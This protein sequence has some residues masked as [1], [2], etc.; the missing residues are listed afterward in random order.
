[1]KQGK[2]KSKAKNKQQT[3]KLEVRGLSKRP[4]LRI[5]RGDLIF[6]AYYQRPLPMP[7]V[8]LFLS[9][10]HPLSPNSLTQQNPPPALPGVDSAALGSFS[11]TN[12]SPTSRSKGEV[13]SQGKSWRIWEQLVTNI[14]SSLAFCI[15]FFLFVWRALHIWREENVLCSWNLWEGGAIK[16]SEKKLRG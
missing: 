13:K 10:H 6:S 4:G 2:S 11:S 12:T 1:M 9:I 5:F 7:F 3:K 16:L 14:F 15:C 8:P